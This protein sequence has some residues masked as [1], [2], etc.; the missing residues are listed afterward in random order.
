M[1]LLGERGA[2]IAYHDRFIP[3]L[4]IGG[5]T[6]RSV[7][8]DDLSAWDAVIIVT[9]HSGIDYAKVVAEARLVIDTRNATKGLRRG[10]GR[11]KIVTL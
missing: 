10:E 2:K 1:E 5:A 7:P 11:A 8:L 9:D 4:E 3:Q 6:Q